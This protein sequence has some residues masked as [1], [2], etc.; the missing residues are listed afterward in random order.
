[1][2]TKL[3]HLCNFGDGGPSSV[4]EI[5]R[6]NYVLV[7]FVHAR[8][9]SRPTNKRSCQLLTLPKSTS[10]VNDVTMYDLQVGRFIACNAFACRASR[11]KL[12]IA[13]FAFTGMKY[14]PAECE[15]R[16][17]ALRPVRLCPPGLQNV[18]VARC[19]GEGALVG[20]GNRHSCPQG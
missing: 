11:T 20:M 18:V 12:S 3:L 16:P 6:K 15:C 19:H 4:A 13:W 2:E 7:Y 1:M 10:L 14:P 8:A 17:F 5:L 9:N